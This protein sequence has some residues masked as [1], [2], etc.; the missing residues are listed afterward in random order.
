M[1][2]CHVPL[3]P[4]EESIRPSVNDIAAYD[5]RRMAREQSQMHPK[6]L[7][8]IVLHG[9]SPGGIGDEEQP[10]TPT[11]MIGTALG[12]SNDLECEWPRSTSLLAIKA[13]I[14]V[15]RRR[16]CDI[17]RIIWKE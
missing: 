10:C 15:D 3:A 16:A 12:D 5:R 9:K 6:Y 4:L 2:P 13:R 14:E 7:K 11:A 1:R 17:L 8:L